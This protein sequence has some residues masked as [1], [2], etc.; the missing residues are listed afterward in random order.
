MIQYFSFSISITL[1][2][3]LIGMILNEVIKNKSY[4]INIENLNFIKNESLNNIIGV[5]LFKWIVKNTFFKYLNQKLKL[6]A[7]IDISQLKEI[8]KDM[9]HAEISH[10]IAFGA[11]AIIAIYKTLPSNYLFGMTI[12][13]INILLNLYPTLL[14]QKNKRRIDKLI[15]KIT[16]S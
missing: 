5:G 9:T 16:H 6:K 2:S 4:Y 7:S 13:I 1:G 3:W 8:R 10:L 12:M 15:Q 11:V 14:Q